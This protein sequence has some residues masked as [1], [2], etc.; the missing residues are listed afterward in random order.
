MV[1]HGS[2][3]TIAHVAR[4][5]H[6][7]GAQLLVV[8]TDHRLV[9]GAILEYCWRNGKL[10]EYLFATRL[11]K[12][13]Q[14]QQQQRDER[15]HLDRRVVVPTHD[16]RKRYTAAP[17]ATATACHTF[18]FGFCFVVV[19]AGVFGISA[20]HARAV[21]HSGCRVAKV[22][23]GAAGSGADSRA[24]AID[25]VGVLL[26][27]VSRQRDRRPRDANAVPTSAAGAY[28]P[29][30]VRTQ[31]AT[32]GIERPR[33]SRSCVARFAINQAR[34]G[35]RSVPHRRATALRRPIQAVCVQ[36]R[37]SGVHRVARQAYGVK[38]VHILLLLLLLLLLRCALLLIDRAFFQSATTSSSSPI[39]RDTFRFTASCAT[40]Y[41]GCR[42][43]S[44]RAPTS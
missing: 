40:P 4:T 13:S 42:V 24:A 12:P 5:A 33:D 15:I 23:V 17:T 7:T 27:G 31:C 38:Y 32:R 8:A 22:V 18:G 28:H 26:F 14:R 41:R 39:D 3:Y 44:A 35:D 20:L 36:V 37:R 29:T 34:G 6:P 30:N 19:G 16:C 25:R 9:V 11:A 1:G 43:V 21:R 10:R 2:D